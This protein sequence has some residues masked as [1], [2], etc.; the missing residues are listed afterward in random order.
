MPRIHAW[1][2]VLAWGLVGCGSEPA[3]RPSNPVPPEIT[4]AQT[5]FTYK[6]R[7]I[8]PFFLAD[9]YGGPDAPDFWTRPMGSRISAIAIDGLFD[10]SDGAYAFAK[11]TVDSGFVNFDIPDPN[12]DSPR[13]GGWFAYHFV[14]TSTSGVT[15][16]EYVGNTGGS[17][18]VP[19]VVFL[20]F[21]MQAVGYT[22]ADRHNRLVMRFLG[23]E[24]WGDRVYRDAKLVGDELRLGPERSD[25]PGAQGSLEPARV[26]HLK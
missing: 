25:M 7:P 3:V 14:G 20:R 16:V 9:F 1:A 22:Q 4:E 18:T 2:V 6:G 23:E 11:V 15:V 21:E 5:H 19:G 12:S 10:R 26:I 8:P 24:C 13:G 17:G